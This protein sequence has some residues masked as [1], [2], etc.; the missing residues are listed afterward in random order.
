MRLRA[1]VSC[2]TFHV[3]GEALLRVVRTC[4]NIFLASK[5]EV[6]QTTAKACLT[7]VRFP[8]SL[9]WRIHPRHERVERSVIKAPV[10]WRSVET[11]LPPSHSP[12]R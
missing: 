2:M 1:Q 3:H 10:W 12:M 4:Y 9:F 8:G 7:Q 11:L 5:S 6:N